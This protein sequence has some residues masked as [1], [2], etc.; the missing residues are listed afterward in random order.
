LM[1]LSTCYV[2]G[3][4]DGRVVEEVQP[5]YTPLGVADFDAEHELHA[6]QEVVAHA[7]ARAESPEIT[8]ALLTQVTG[9]NLPSTAASLT[10]QIASLE[11]RF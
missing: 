8:A 1:H 11:A 5:D 6:L 7:E 9:M 2:V 4:K 3:G 10:D